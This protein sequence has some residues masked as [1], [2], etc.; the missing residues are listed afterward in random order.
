M[1]LLVAKSIVEN[2]FRYTFG[3]YAISEFVVNL[4]TLTGTFQIGETLRGTESDENDVFIKSVV[5]G[6]PT[7]KNIINDGALNNLGDKIVLT[8][9]GIGG[10][11]ATSNI[12]GG[13]LSEIIVGLR[14]F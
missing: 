12:G 2:V 8:G 13:S 9:G 3:E 5:T 4:D 6:I 10:L 14:W 7:T 1:K 11:F